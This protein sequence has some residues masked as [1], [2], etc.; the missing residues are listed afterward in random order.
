M[1]LFL[2]IAALEWIRATI[3]FASQRMDLGEPWIRLVIILSAVTLFTLLSS[4]LFQNKTLVQKYQSAK[5][6]AN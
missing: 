1:R 3:V 4:F 6:T 5:D 2:V